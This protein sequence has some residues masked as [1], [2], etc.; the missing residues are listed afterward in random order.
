MTTKRKTARERRLEVELAETHAIWLRSRDEV[1]KL[2]SEKV[3]LLSRI[4]GYEG[5]RKRDREATLALLKE[6]IVG[7]AIPNA[8]NSAQFTTTI[9]G[10]E[11]G[12]WKLA[13]RLAPEVTVGEINKLTTDITEALR[14]DIVNALIAHRE[15][16]LASVTEYGETIA[17]CSLWRFPK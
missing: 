17:S 5:L 4:D 7:V 3:A 6:H 12:I 8:T 2:K 13:R 1:E 11:S 10:A 9:D 14:Y 15:T 16:V